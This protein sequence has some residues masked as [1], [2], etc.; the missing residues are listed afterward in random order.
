MQMGTSVVFPCPLLRY[1]PVTLDNVEVKEGDATAAD[2]SLKP[3]VA[4]PAP[5]P[6]QAAPVAATEPVANA[7]NATSTERPS[8]AHPSI[9]PE[10]F[11]HHHFPDM[12]IFLRKYAT[13]YPNI[14]RLYSVG[15][16]VEQ[17]ELYAMEISDNPGVHE[18]GDVVGPHPTPGLCLRGG[19]ENARWTLDRGCPFEGAMLGTG[20]LAPCRDFRRHNL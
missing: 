4:A 16:S 14:A 9:Q 6:T 19:G 2:F 1:L 10:D 17:R 15:K 12:G 7:T 18:A 5:D 3:T 11:R 20:S 8:M 13:E